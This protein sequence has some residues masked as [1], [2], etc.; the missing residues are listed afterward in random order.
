MQAAER[1]GAL[2]P[3]FDKDSTPVIEFAGTVG[4]KSAREGRLAGV[5][6][7]RLALSILDASKTKDRGSFLEVDASEIE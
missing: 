7:S 5:G 6:K 4:S 1:G 2:S 3:V